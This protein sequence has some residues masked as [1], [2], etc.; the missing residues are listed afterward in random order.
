[1]RAPYTQPPQSPT[2]AARVTE[3][4]TG[5]VLEVLTDDLGLQLYTASML[6]GSLIGKSGTPYR[7]HRALCLECQGHPDGTRWPEFGDILV[8]PEKPQR[9]TTIYAFSAR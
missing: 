8:Y 4:Q 6:D 5:R 3:P 1:M 9:R 2:L 7:K